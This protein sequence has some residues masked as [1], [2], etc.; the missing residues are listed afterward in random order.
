MK[1]VIAVTGGIAAYKVPSII[2]GLRKAIQDDGNTNPEVHVIT[3]EN[4]LKFVTET[5]LMTSANQYINA[6]M[7]QNPVIMHQNPSHITLSEIANM[8][9]VVPATAN[10]VGK[11]ANGIADDLVTSTVMALSSSTKKIIC[12]SMNTR[13]MDNVAMKRNIFTLIQDGWKII[14]PISGKLACGTVGRG[15]LAKTRDIVRQILED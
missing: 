5:T 3:T 9:I 14:E 2:S 1:I 15:K 8:F 4:A 13:M 11:I 12:P 7:V 6:D 10:I